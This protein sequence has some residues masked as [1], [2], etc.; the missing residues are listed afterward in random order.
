M[1][2]NETSNI[3]FIRSMFIKLMDIKINVF[4]EEKDVCMNFIYKRL[5][6]LLEPTMDV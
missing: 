5:N 2:I 4:N 1:Y 6:I 3:Y